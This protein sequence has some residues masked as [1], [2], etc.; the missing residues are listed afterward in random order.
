MTFKVLSPKQAKIFKWAYNTDYKA[1]IC[2]G[3]VRSGKTICMITSYILWAMRAFKGANFGICGKTVA[4]AERNIVKPLQE[5]ADITH[6]FSV[7]YRSGEHVLIIGTDTYSNYFYVFGG[8]DQSSY[9]LLQGITLSGIFFDEVALMPE[10]FVQQ[11]LARCLSVGES[12]YWFNCNPESPAHWFYQQWI[13]EAEK[14]NALHIHMLM[15]DNPILTE[16]ELHEAEVR[17]SGVFYDRYILGLWCLAEGLIYPEYERAIEKPPADA[18]YDKYELSIDYGT[19]N[20]FAALMWG[21]Y[22]GVWYAFDGYYHS[23]RETGK[24]LTDEEYGNEI[25]KRF[26]KYTDDYDK[27]TVYIDP[28]AASFITLMRRKRRYHI[29]A[30]DN[31]VLD[32][33]RETATAIHNDL[34]K[35][36]PELG[37]MRKEFEGYVWDDNSNDDRPVKE[38]DHGMD[39][40]RYKVK[41]SKIAVPKTD[42]Y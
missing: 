7:Q 39:S 22:K 17:F 41:T 33:I 31:A 25:D 6:Y 10:N 24:Q 13:L 11:G 16:K 15:S 32:G 34:I 23:G 9:Q 30:A 4:S 42:L 14:Q 5:I 2:D 40:L 27:M 20:A 12:K 19:L 1:I 21:R 28:S 38:A 36:S 18:K 8:K 37:W 26:G 29:K 3:A 35:I